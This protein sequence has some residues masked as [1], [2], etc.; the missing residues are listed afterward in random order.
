MFLQRA[1][2]LLHF[3]HRKWRKLKVFFPTRHCYPFIQALQGVT[4]LEPKSLIGYFVLLKFVLILKPSC[5][6]P[7][8]SLS[9]LIWEMNIIISV[10][11]F[12]WGFNECGSTFKKVLSKSKSLFLFLWQDESSKFYPSVLFSSVPFSTSSRKPLSSLFVESSLLEATCY[13]VY[14]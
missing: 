11:V 2:D 12:F 3:C 8:A 9:F 6:V 10:P 1:S 13:R 7:S 5:S 14:L 4:F